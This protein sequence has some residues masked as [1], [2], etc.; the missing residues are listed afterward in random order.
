M[1]GTVLQLAP[2]SASPVPAG[3]LVAGDVDRLTLEAALLAE[4]GAIDQDAIPCD[5]C[6][7]PAAIHPRPVYALADPGHDH[8]IPPAY[9]LAL[10][11]LAAEERDFLDDVAE[12]LAAEYRPSGSKSPR[13][14]DAGTCERSVWYRIHPPADY[15]P[16]TD[17][18]RKAA[19]LGQLI[20]KAGETYRPARYP[21]RRFEMRIRVPGLDG[22][23]YRVDEYDPVTGTVFDTKSAG[24]NKWIILADGPVD[25]MWEQA[26]VYAWALYLAGYPVRRLCII[27]VNRENGTE[28][29]HWEEFDPEL[30]L[31]AL[32]KL[33]ALGTALDAGV[34][35]DRAGRGPRHWMCQWCEAMNH[36]WNT[37][38]AARMGRGPVSLTLLGAQPGEDAIVWVG[39]E[40][41]RLSAERLELQG[42]EAFA[43]DLLQGLPRG[44]YGAAREDGGIEITDKTSTSVGYKEYV[45][46]LLDLWDLPDDER[47]PAAE[48]PGPAVSK[49]ITQAAKKP[50]RAAAST[51]KRKRKP[52][53][54][55]SA[56]AAV[57]AAAGN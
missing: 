14:S 17:I 43:K 15:V 7:M 31:A 22:D 18:D 19:T 41:M 55:E 11:A 54:G 42:R 45:E 20:H 27:A 50:G 34:V 3:E 25:S 56:A 46:Y 8:Q 10:A 29:K 12:G 16:R 49:S 23:N 4:P 2:A 30:C 33:I 24:K 39:R 38:Q 47:P 32:G 9:A 48:L 36:C 51:T 37:E 52:T 1:S 57:E 6:G 40:A 53:P 35:P 44:T 26:R 21:W 28:E 13:P 5:G